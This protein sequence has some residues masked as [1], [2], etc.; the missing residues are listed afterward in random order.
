[1]GLLLSAALHFNTPEDQRFHRGGVCA[2]RGK[3]SS[4]F[5][6]CTTDGPI[7]GITEGETDAVFRRRNP[8]PVKRGQN[9]EEEGVSKRLGGASVSANPAALNH[10]RGGREE[11]DKN[12]AWEERDE[13]RV[14]RRELQEQGCGGVG[15]VEGWVKVVGR[16]RQVTLLQRTTRRIL[17]QEANEESGITAATRRSNVLFWGHKG[18]LATWQQQQV[19]KK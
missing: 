11:G 1:M 7:A 10:A 13:L 3:S 18:P 8:P 15:G 12:K 17:G 9:A 6:C 19:G 4:I 16:G 2:R 5:P 14:G